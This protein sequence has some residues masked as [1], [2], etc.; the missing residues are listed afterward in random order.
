MGAYFLDTSALVK[1]YHDEDG[2]DQVDAI[3]DDDGGETRRP[4]PD[5]RHGQGSVE[6][7]RVNT[8]SGTGF[9]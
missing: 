2:T 5:R 7:K 9:T 1:R 8:S 4:V 3:L 6:P